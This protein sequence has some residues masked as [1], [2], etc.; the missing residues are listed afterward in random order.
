MRHI[1]RQ[2]IVIIVLVVI[3]GFPDTSFGVQGTDSEITPIV[4]GPESDCRSAGQS[5]L[6]LKLFRGHFITTAMINGKELRMLVDSGASQSAIS[7]R[8]AKVMRLVS[9]LEHSVH[10]LSVEGTEIVHPVKVQS[11]KLGAFEWNNYEL[12]PLHIV[13]PAQEKDPVAPDGLIGAD[14]LSAFDVEFDFPKGRMTLY[15]KLRCTGTLVPW[16]GRFQTIEATRVQGK[17]LTIQVLLDGHPLRA[18]IDTGSD[19]SN[20][21]RNAAISAGVDNTR[22][23]SGP[24]GIGIGSQGTGVPTHYNQFATLTLGNR[25]FDNTSLIVLDSALSPGI[26]MLLGNSYFRWH[27]LWLSYSTN[28]VFVQ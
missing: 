21:T 1:F 13:D 16:E 7:L 3:S 20:V 27:K 8:T 25:Q 28:Q 12:T 6:P 17:L 11:I 18:L 24:R 4:L 5:T 9:N 2:V 15:D 22:I 23:D 26:D 19:A 10:I 14:L